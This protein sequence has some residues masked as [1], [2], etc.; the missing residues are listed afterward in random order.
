MTKSLNCALW[1]ASVWVVV[2]GCSPVT[3]GEE[4]AQS[5]LKARLEHLSRH[6]ISRVGREAW[7][8][9]YEDVI[10]DFP[11]NPGVAEA[12]LRVGNMYASTKI[13]E[14]NILPDE[15]KAL[16]WFR[17]AAGTA[18]VGSDLWVQAKL[19]IS[20]IL[21]RSDRTASRECI[22]EIQ[23]IR[24]DSL[25][26]ARA[27]SALQSIAITEGNLREAEL[28]CVRL[29]DWYA[30][31]ERIPKNDFDKM[32]VDGMIRA[33]GSFMIE[34]YRQA[35]LSASERYGLIL[36]LMREHCWMSLQ[37]DGFEALE[38]LKPL[39]AKEEAE[40]RAEHERQL[41]LV[42]PEEVLKT[43][44]A[45]VDARPADA[46][47][48]SGV[49]VHVDTASLPTD[50]VVDA[51]QRM[52]PL[53]WGKDLA[54]AIAQEKTCAEVIAHLAD[55]DDLSL[56]TS[57]ISDVPVSIDNADVQMRVVI[58]LMRV[59][60]LI[61]DGRRDPSTV[62]K[63]L[64]VEL[65]RSVK[66][67]PRLWEKQLATGPR[68]LAE[69]DDYMRAQVKALAATYI[70]AELG[71][72][73][74]L[75]LLLMSYKF[76]STPGMFHPVPPAITLVAMHRM[77]ERMPDEKLDAR[78]KDAKAAYL[79]EA[80]TAIPP[81]KEI[82]VTGSKAVYQ[83]SDPRFFAIDPRKLVLADQPRIHLSLYPTR[84]LDGTSMFT[85]RPSGDLEVPATSS[86]LLGLIES[87]VEEASDH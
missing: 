13:P 16:E 82:T 79:A 57:S 75:P 7:V 85:L 39:V 11:S 64:R 63:L 25:T 66:E 3:L 74:S 29:L 44:P 24:R 54:S 27:E 46:G 18:T 53:K 2:G 6:P 71:Q 59:R 31:K 81:V 49:A 10:R 42:G 21:R 34:T 55:F 14:L 32:E 4:K 77:V 20:G 84:F 5:T 58:R 76:N 17:R 47:D 73:D 38:S 19:H 1:I 15:C 62:S 78:A 52:P 45:P 67:W 40:R 83:E 23:Q 68:E 8:Q 51:K 33:A 50:A 65:E 12:M 22:A 9:A 86:K 28:H 70:L 87:F 35:Q 43:A 37:K 60:R 61:E 26:L 36:N 72:Y 69:P 48:E 41:P 30:D 56:A 80:L